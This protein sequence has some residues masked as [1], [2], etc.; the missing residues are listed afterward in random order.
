MDTKRIRSHF[1]LCALSPRFSVGAKIADARYQLSPHETRGT[2]TK[3]RHRAGV[4]MMAAVYSS[5]NG[6]RSFAAAKPVDL[7]KVS[8]DQ[9]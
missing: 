7:A 5:V 9:Y 1:T 8:A 6:F 3:L 4:G 2:I